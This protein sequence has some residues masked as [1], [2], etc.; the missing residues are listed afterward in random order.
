MH[1]AKQ[2][3]PTQPILSMSIILEGTTRVGGLGFKAVA[4]IFR[5][6]VN[7]SLIYVNIVTSSI[8]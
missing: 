7:S 1:T 5:D 3:I 2:W 6:T 4:N 8:I